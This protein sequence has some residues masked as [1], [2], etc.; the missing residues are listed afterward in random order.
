MEAKSIS[1]LTMRKLSFV[2]L[3]QEIQT[4]TV[5]SIQHT[6]VHIIIR[7]STENV[8]FNALERTQ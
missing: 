3:K 8:V 4:V 5:F 6:Y 7:I 1:D 2:Y